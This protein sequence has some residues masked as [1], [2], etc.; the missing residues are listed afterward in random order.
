MP[1]KQIFSYTPN[2]VIPII[3]LHGIL[4][5]RLRLTKENQE[6]LKKKDSVSYDPDDKL[7]MV[8]GLGRMDAKERQL[9]FN[10]NGCEID[11][12]DTLPDAKARADYL[13]RSKVSVDTNSPFLCDDTSSAPNAKTAREK[14]CERGWGE[15][16]F[17]SYGVILN[18]MELMM[19]RRMPNGELNPEWKKIIG[20]D[21]KTWGN[22]GKTPDSP[23]ELKPLTED[24]LK[25]VGGEKECW[26]PVHAVGY[27]WVRSN[28]VESKYVAKRI[29]AIMTKYTTQLMEC[30]KV[31]VVTHSMG[32][33]VGRAL[34]HPKYGNIQDLILG[35]VHGEQ[36]AMGAAAA[37]YRMLAGFEYPDHLSS[38]NPDKQFGEI[39]SDVLGS[40]GSLVTVILANGG[41]GLELLPSR[42]YGNKWL[43]AS[44]KDYWRMALPE[45]GDPYEEIYKKEGKEAW[46]GLLREKWINPAG[47]KE[48]SSLE[49]TREL[50]DQA[51]AFHENISRTYHP[52][53]YAH[54]GCDSKRP[55]FRNIWWRVED[56]K[57]PATL[58]GTLLDR[59]YRRATDKEVDGVNPA[60]W[61]LYDYPDSF[62]S[63]EIYGR[64]L[65]LYLD[66]PRSI[67]DGTGKKTNDTP[68]HP[69]FFQVGMSPP[70]APGDQTVPQHS[71]EHQAEFGNL[72]G[73][74]RQKGYEHQTSYQDENA[75]AATLYSIVLIAKTMQW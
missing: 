10:P 20:V 42:D 57:H 30:K 44:T 15:L 50:L 71:A 36:P 38:F 23:G 66:N 51:K 48:G 2:R 37:Y 35:V 8:K 6:K 27:N 75:I 53:T 32:G 25:K 63:R 45:N 13:K 68:E 58:P 17:N 60:E 3:F 64:A 21:P 5:G 52:V 56:L 59:Q 72:K 61:R 34:C 4:G 12:Y 7:G 28:T 70:E 54:W 49:K 62:E 9:M 22:E 47:V 19:N 43:R 39:T 55:A 1:T 14:A 46:C 24:D 18:R 74:F 16:N 31:I 41:G 65:P 69:R 33:I 67:V 73:I 40:K 11:S 29:K 26:F